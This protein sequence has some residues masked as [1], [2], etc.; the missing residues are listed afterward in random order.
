[1]EDMRYYRREWETVDSF[2]WRVCRRYAS[3]AV[4]LTGEYI[5]MMDV[6]RSF[7]F[8][9]CLRVSWWA[10]TGAVLISLRTDKVFLARLSLIYSKSRKHRLLAI[11]FAPWRVS[12]LSLGPSTTA[13]R[14]LV[15][16]SF[17][18][19]LSIRHTHRARRRD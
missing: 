19:G 10:I 8:Y 11:G 4:N 18:K 5:C 3:P 1:M 7:V 6:V 15:G 2:Y 12:P 14:A 16:L 9:L 17:A 13:A